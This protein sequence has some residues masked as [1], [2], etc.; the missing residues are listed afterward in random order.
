MPNAKEL[1]LRTVQRAETPNCDNRRDIPYCPSALE[2][3]LA[4]SIFAMEK[5]NRE[6]RGF[7]R[8]GV[9][10]VIVILTDEDESGGTRPDA[11]LASMRSQFGDSKKLMVHGVI[12][13]P[14]DRECRRQQGNGVYSSIVADMI[15]R[16]NGS[17]HSIC[18]ADYGRSLSHISQQT[19][20]LLSTFE[21]RQIPRPGSVRVTLA[22]ASNATWRV[23]GRRLIFENP[24]P[25]GTEIRVEYRP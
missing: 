15:A 13:R 18:E 8:P 14:G 10:L 12:I 25:A 9:D 5:R 1:F 20:Q 21:L 22:P 3:P 6:N 17:A 24:P 11:V 2:Q 4:A 16:T 23:E 7:F 19:R